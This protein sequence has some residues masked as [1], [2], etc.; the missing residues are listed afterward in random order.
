MTTRLQLH[1]RL[2]AARAA[3]AVGFMLSGIAFAMVCPKEAEAPSKRKGGKAAVRLSPALLVRVF[4][5]M[6]AV[7]VVSSLLFNF[8]TNG[9]SQLLSEGFR[10]VLEDPAILGALLAL[11]YTIASLKDADL[12]LK[13]VN[14]GSA[15]E[16]QILRELIFRIVY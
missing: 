14:A 13:G 5:V 2:P 4:A 3:V 16:G 8:T 12:K 9:N 1:R 15:S 7:A 6:T 11:I 10:G